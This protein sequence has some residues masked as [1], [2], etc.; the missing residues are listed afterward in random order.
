MLSVDA[1]DAHGGGHGRG[2]RMDRA[3]LVRGLY[4][5][6]M[7]EL[8]RGSAAEAAGWAVAGVGKRHDGGVGGGDGRCAHVGAAWAAHD[9]VAAAAAAVV[10]VVAGDDDVDGVR[11]QAVHDGASGRQ[12]D[13]GLRKWLTKGPCPY[14]ELKRRLL[15]W[16]Y[17]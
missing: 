4:R 7:V 11:G 16:C 6:S 3:R 17:C 8:A 2:R 15:R 12:E 13:A 10:A 9:S 5:C 1:G 14:C